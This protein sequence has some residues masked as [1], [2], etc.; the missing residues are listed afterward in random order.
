MLRMPLNLLLNDN[1][2]TLQKEKKRKGKK[3]KGQK[4]NLA[5][6]ETAKAIALAYLDG[7]THNHHEFRACKESESLEDASF[8]AVLSFNSSAW[9]LSISCGKGVRQLSLLLA[10][11]DTMP[12][13]SFLGN[14]IVHCGVLTHS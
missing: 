6:N 5:T 3:R 14:N 11:H 2:S 4:R 10:E 12:L 9:Y 1:M 13:H 7:R 8:R